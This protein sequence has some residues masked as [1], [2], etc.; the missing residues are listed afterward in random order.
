MKTTKKKVSLSTKFV[1]KLLNFQQE[2]YQKNTAEQ[3]FAEDIDNTNLLKL[4]H[5][6]DETWVHNYDNKRR[7]QVR[8]NVKVSFLTFFDYNVYYELLPATIY[9]VNK[10]YY[11]EVLYQLCEPIKKKK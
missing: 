4:N 1:P 7:A 10:K 2:Q 11:L 9:T 5:N 6:S 8:F 3:M